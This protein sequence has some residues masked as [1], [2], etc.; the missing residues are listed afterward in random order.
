MR[1][2]VVLPPVQRLDHNPAGRTSGRL[3]C[4]SFPTSSADGTLLALDAIWR[5]VDTPDPA[6]AAT[7]HLV[8]VDE[9]WQLLRDGA[10]AR[11]C[12]P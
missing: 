4:A 10:G 7:R 2:R 12:W 8:V 11:S 9:A 6:R 5:D 3:V 1:R